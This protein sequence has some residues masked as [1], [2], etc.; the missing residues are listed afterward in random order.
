MTERER[1]E[2]DADSLRLLHMYESEQ[3]APLLNEVDELSKRGRVSPAVMGIAA[4]SLTALERYAEAAKAAAE[5]LRRS[6]SSA[7]LYHTL[8]SVHGGEGKHREA[9]SAQVRATQLMPGEPVY[10]AALAGYQRLAG[11]TEQA[12][13]TARQATV[14]GPDSP[15]VRNELGLALEAGG[16]SAEALAQFRQAQQTAPADPA[17]YLYEGSLHLRA[18]DRPAARAALRAALQRRPGLAA[19][20]NRMAET[21]TGSSGPLRKALLHVL[22]LG[23]VTLVGWL[24]IGFLYYL[25]YRLLEF[26]WAMAPVL[27]TG[28]RILLLAALVYLLGGAILGTL[29][30][31]AFRTG[32]PR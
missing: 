15:A 32:W 24:M 20:E 6:P 9:I 11:D 17:A 3:H 7:W 13:R 22:N 8:A 27:H 10:L 26:L 19:A 1:A 30:R 31:F 16:K 21:L 28:G 23:R 25:L 18:G 12:V 5:A 29:L 14:T 4:L 2:L